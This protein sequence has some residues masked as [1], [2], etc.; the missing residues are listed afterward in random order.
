MKSLITIIIVLLASVVNAQV[1]TVNEQYM[2][3][4]ITGDDI[5]SD[6]PLIITDD[7]V[8][9]TPPIE[10][11]PKGKGNKK[12]VKPTVS[13]GVKYCIHNVQSCTS[14]SDCTQNSAPGVPP[15]ENGPICIAQICTTGEI[16]L[17]DAECQDNW[18]SDA[19]REL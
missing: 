5:V 2:P 13:L 18:T 11:A 12:R 8:S 7:V 1:P 10:P 15:Y 6:T 4:I 9:D 16:C 14:N 3:P 17:T 19:C